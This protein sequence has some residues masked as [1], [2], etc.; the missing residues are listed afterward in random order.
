[1]QECKS[2]EERGNKGGE[3][4]R[5]ASGSANLPESRESNELSTQEHQRG[6]KGGRNRI[7]LFEGGAYR[8]QAISTRI[9]TSGIRS[10]SSAAAA[11]RRDLNAFRASPLAKFK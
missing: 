3:E 4:R 9:S 8:V 6:R 7:P 5:K 1:V 2:P 10:G 11:L